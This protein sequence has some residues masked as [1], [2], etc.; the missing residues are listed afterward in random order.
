MKRMKPKQSIALCMISNYYASELVYETRLLTILLLFSPS[1][2]P[3]N[4]ALS[5]NRTYYT[6]EL[7]C[8][9]T[10]ITITPWQSPISWAPKWR[11]TSLSIAIWL[12]Y[13]RFWSGHTDLMPLFFPCV[14]FPI[15]IYQHSYPVLNFSLKHRYIFLGFITDLWYL[16]SLD[17]HNSK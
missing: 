10:L 5:G 2:R 14:L 13:P 16:I 12:P 1:T 8:V 11:E 17:R 15:F 6:S 3:D 9:T 4:R 7:I